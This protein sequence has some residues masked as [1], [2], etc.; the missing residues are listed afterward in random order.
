MLCFPTHVESSLQFF[1]TFPFT[2]FYFFQIFPFF[3]IWCV[4]AA[5]YMHMNSIW[6]CSIFILIWNQLSS[7]FKLSLSLLLIFQ[8]KMS[9]EYSKWVWFWLLYKFLFILIWNILYSYG[10]FYTHLEYS[11]LIWNILYSFGIFYTHIEYSIW[12]C[13]LR[14]RHSHF[15]WEFM[16]NHRSYALFMKNISSYSYGIHTQNDS[17]NFSKKVRN[18]YGDDR[19]HLGFI[20]I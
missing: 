18:A 19:T 2:T 14:A 20:R 5:D 15:I 11:I 17:S 10:I 12:V 3:C 13:F 4:D 1:Q 7:F 16:K 8:L 6:V 9:I